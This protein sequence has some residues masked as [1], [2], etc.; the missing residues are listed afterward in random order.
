MPYKPTKERDAYLSRTEQPPPPI[1]NGVIQ[2]GRYK[3]RKCDAV[4]SSDPSWFKWACEN[5]RDFKSLSGVNV[6]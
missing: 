5:V 3:G 1:I 2:I 6:T 4:R